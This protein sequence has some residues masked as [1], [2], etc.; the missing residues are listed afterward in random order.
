MT[1]LKDF[2]QLWR[3]YRHC[4]GPIKAARLAWAV[5]RD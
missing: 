1:R 3:I 5:A 4:N 2:I